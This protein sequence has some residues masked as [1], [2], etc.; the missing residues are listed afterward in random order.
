MG[1]MMYR[2]CAQFAWIRTYLANVLLGP[3]VAGMSFTKNVSVTTWLTKWSKERL[4]VPRADRNSATLHILRFD[5]E[6]LLGYC[7]SD[8]S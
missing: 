7:I 3:P 6:L 5:D 1:V 4:L 2:I 8:R